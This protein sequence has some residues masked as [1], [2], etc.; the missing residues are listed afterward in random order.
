[1]TDITM[2]MTGLLMTKQ[3]SLPNSVNQPVT[4]PDEH[5][6]KTIQNK[7]YQLVIKA[8]N[9]SNKLKWIS[10]NL[11]NTSLVPKYQ[12]HKNRIAKIK[13]LFFQEK[14][15]VESWEPSS[16]KS[17]K[18]IAKLK[19]YNFKLGKSRNSFLLNREGGID[20]K[21]NDIL[22]TSREGVANRALPKLNFTTSGVSVRVLQ[23]LLVANG[24]PVQ[25]D[26]VFGPVTEIAVKAFQEKQKLK[27]DGIV[28]VETWYC[29][30]TYSK[31]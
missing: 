15:Y 20:E 11:T 30:T 24:Y 21:N 6:Q 4:Y 2:L 9:N 29:L 3:V 27:V 23:R 5:N 7:T 25:I 28:G 12:N 31:S 17:K 8:Q 16:D 10:K 26:G 1:M 18:I 14:N 13:K 19:K 22:I